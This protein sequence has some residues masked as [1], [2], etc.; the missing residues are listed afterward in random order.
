MSHLVQEH[1]VLR[2]RLLQVSS[3]IRDV[4]LCE[5]AMPFNEKDKFSKKQ[6]NKQINKQTK[7]NKTNKKQNKKTLF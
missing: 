5:G 1:Y 7:Q 4:P 2:P 3:I 6:T